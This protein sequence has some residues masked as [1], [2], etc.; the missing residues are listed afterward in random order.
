MRERAAKKSEGRE[1][2]FDDNA[3]TCKVPTTTI[4]RYWKGGK[5]GRYRKRALGSKV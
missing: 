4:G 5:G 3:R 1:Q 2:V